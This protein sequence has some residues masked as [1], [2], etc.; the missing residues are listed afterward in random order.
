MN[1]IAFKPVSSRALKAAAP[2]QLATGKRSSTNR[3][4]SPA[5]PI[6]NNA[7]NACG[8]RQ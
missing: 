4:V 3:A 5:A 6:V 1:T 8:T 7:A 2:R